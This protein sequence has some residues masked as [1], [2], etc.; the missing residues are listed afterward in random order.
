MTAAADSN[1]ISQLLESADRAQ[2]NGLGSDAARLIAEA[3]A[4][5]PADSRVLNALGLQALRENDPTSARPQLEQAVAQTPR[6]PVLWLNLAQCRG[7]QGDATGEL[8]ALDQALSLQPRFYPALLAKATWL[9][10][11]GKPK[12]AVHVYNFFLHCLPPPPQLPPQLK[13][14]IDYAQRIVSADRAARR[15]PSTRR[16]GP[17]PNSAPRPPV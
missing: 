10:R 17:R 13:P 2:A 3:R 8:A 9:E 15:G 11:Q 5:A 6:E 4:L 7:M 16:H 1:R 12:Q 14:A